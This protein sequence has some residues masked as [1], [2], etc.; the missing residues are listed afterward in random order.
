M[1]HAHVGD[2][3]ETHI[4]TLPVRARSITGRTG[5]LAARV[6]VCATGFFLWP[7]MPVALISVSL[8]F[9]AVAVHLIA[10]VT[11]QEAE[12]PWCKTSIRFVGRRCRCS[13]CEQ[14]IIVWNNEV[15]RGPFDT[16]VGRFG[17]R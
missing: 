12:C 10:A 7:N 15:M 13:T 2:A 9:V 11:S 1:I 14:R 17:P 6:G 5:M 16:I 4:V 3:V 8:A